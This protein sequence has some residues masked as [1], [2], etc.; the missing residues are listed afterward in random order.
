LSSSD[1]T[2]AGVLTMSLATR[3]SFVAAFI[4]LA[5]LSACSGGGAPL[6]PGASPQTQ[7]SQPPQPAPKSIASTAPASATTQQPASAVALI[8]VSVNGA[9]SIG[10]PGTYGLTIVAENAN[11]T[12]ISGPYGAPI[13]LSDDDPTG[14]TALS[15]KTVSSSST[16]V[17]ISYTGLGGSAQG[18][19]QGATVTATSG[20]VA[21]EVGFLSSGAGCVTIKGIA[22]YYPC[23]LQDAYSLPSS[24]RGVGQTVAVVDAFDDPNAEADLGVYRAEFGLPPCTTANHCFKK[25]NQ[26][27]DEGNLPYPDTTGWS[28]EVSLDVQMVSAICPNCHILLVEANSQQFSDLGAGVDAAARLGANQISNSY[29]VKEPS[30]APGFDI[31]FNHPSAMIVASSGDTGYQSPEY[32]A[33]SPYVTAVGG[34]TLTP[35]NNGRGWS[36]TV[37]HN[38]YGADG[39]GC[40][41][42]EPKPAWQLDPSCPNRMDDDVAAVADPYTG[43]AFYDS[44]IVL[45]ATY[46][47]W[48]VIGGTS[49]SAP[50][51]AATYALGG[52][53]PATLN[54]GSASYRANPTALNDITSG[55]NGGCANT[56]LYWCTAGVGYDG[57]TGNG[58]PNGVGAFGGP[59]LASSAD[60]REAPHRRARRTV[61]QLPAGTPAVR[62]CP[63]QPGMFAC[64]AIL[65][66]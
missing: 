17:S 6:A 1:L 46:G 12:V 5:A 29:G 66:Q 38:P 19:F 54:Y 31:H 51:I 8:S 2:I 43:F 45:H 14:A 42:L 25:V 53:K 59:N 41:S 52:A 50:L 44:Y 16:A 22:G 30:N 65:M 36:E 23:D 11:G 62:V 64:D 3:P 21:G 32:P 9:P 15:T 60:K 57:P 39:S 27:G 13:L 49:A 37:W 33:T 55:A 28:V 56:I 40:S 35:A 20:S 34:T 63:P 4:A 48:G 18:G 26:S 61:L 10:S 47:G 7:A 58:T 24:T